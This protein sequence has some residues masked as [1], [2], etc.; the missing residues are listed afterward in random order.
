MREWFKK[1]SGASP[2]TVKPSREENEA[3]TVFQRFKKSLKK[4]RETLGR[5][6]EQMLLTKKN[7]DPG[8]IEDIETVLLQADLGIET[9]QYLLDTVNDRIN[10][11]VLGDGPAVY[12]ALIEI[13]QEMLVASNPTHTHNPDLSPPNSPHMP[14]VILAVG[15]NGVGK[16][17]TIGKLAHYY[18]NQG[19]RVMLAAGDTFRAA[20][21]EQL[22]VWG[23][24]N[25]IPVIAQKSGADSA[26]VSYD[27]LSA[28]IARKMDVLLIDTA[29]R[30][31]T[32]NNLMEELKKIK[33]VLGKL[34]PL[35][36][37]ETLLILDASIGQNALNQAREFHQA[38]GV[39][40]IVMSKLDGTA[41]GGIVFAIANEL[42]I[43]FRYIGIGEGIED[44]RP[45][46]PVDFVEALFSND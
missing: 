25:D 26:S 3:V 42:K 18:Q 23:E 27:A 9:T 34:D 36:P 41:K 17:T 8:L 2:E 37:H 21:I 32:Q 16:T 45:F 6:L 31:H 28:A 19:L 20:A 46:E 33:R 29:G 7:I 43:P 30:L 1:K 10:R 38:I 40:G 24:R 11:H 4:T 44:L 22:E 5:T 15:V 39:T 35:A 14:R 13:L 12:K